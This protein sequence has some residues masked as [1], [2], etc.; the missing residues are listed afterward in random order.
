MRNRLSHWLSLLKTATSFSPGTAG[1][2]PQSPS[3]TPPRLMRPG[4]GSARRPAAGVGAGFPGPSAPRGRGPPNNGRGSLA[5]RRRVPKQGRG[6]A[7]QTSPKPTQQRRRGPFDPGEFV[8]NGVLESPGPGPPGVNLRQRCGH[9]PAHGFWPDRRKK[10]A[11]PPLREGSPTAR[12]LGNVRGS[13]RSPRRGKAPRRRPPAPA[14]SSN[15]DDRRGVDAGPKPASSGSAP[16]RDFCAAAV[17]PS[18]PKKLPPSGLVGNGTSEIGGGSAPLR[19]F[20]DAADRLVQAAVS[21]EAENAGPRHARRRRRRWPQRFSDG[22]PRVNSSEGSSVVESNDPLIA[23]SA[24]LRV[25]KSRAGRKVVAGGLLC[26]I[27]TAAV[28]RY[29]AWSG[30][31]GPA[32]RTSIALFPSARHVLRFDHRHPS[33]R[34]GG[35]RGQ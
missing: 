23:A 17:D 33:G 26:S 15:R 32:P 27:R 18:G 6:W 13:G 25:G 3:G 22:R 1:W 8:S 10:E 28:E 12:P 31:R 35:S 4:P 34:S 14:S 11:L 5:A 2:R 24:S 9:R 29:P 20:D 30:N 21:N 7:V 16:G 19:D